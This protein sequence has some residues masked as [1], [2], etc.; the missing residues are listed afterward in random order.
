MT[1]KLTLNHNQVRQGDVFVEKID[2][3]VPPSLLSL[4][5]S[6]KQDVI[7]AFGEVTGHSHKMLRQMH[8]DGGSDAVSYA[9]PVAPT[10]PAIV[11][12]LAPV[13]LVHEEH[14]TIPLP[15]GV[16]RVSRPYEYVAPDIVRRVED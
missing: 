7:L 14:S 1:K 6:A 5:D 3:T 2:G 12:L 16:V 4:E 10:E 15:V 8:T 13:C 11:K 9:H